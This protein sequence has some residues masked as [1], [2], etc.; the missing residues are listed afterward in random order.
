MTRT[1][2]L[3]ASTGT[4]GN[5]TVSVILL[6]VVGVLFVVLTYVRYIKGRN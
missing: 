4:H 5:S 2:T 1:T 3:A 6:V